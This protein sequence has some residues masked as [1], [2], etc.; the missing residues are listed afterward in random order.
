MKLTKQ[1]TQRHVE[2]NRRRRKEGRGGG[3][4]GGKKKKKINQKKKKKKKKKKSYKKPYGTNKQTKNRNKD[5][6][7][8]IGDG[9]RAVIKQ[10]HKDNHSSLDRQ[11]VIH[12]LVSFL[13]AE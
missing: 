11:Q 6:E 10:Y 3:G 2:D 9:R 8:S 5:K 4:G 12:K 13:S 7:D 1:H